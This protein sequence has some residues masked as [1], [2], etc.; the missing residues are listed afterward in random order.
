LIAINSKPYWLNHT[1]FAGEQLQFFD[2]LVMKS[3]CCEISMFRQ[4]DEN[5][6]GSLEL[7][8]FLI[9][10]VKAGVPVGNGCFTAQFHE[11]SWGFH[12]ETWVFIWI[13]M[14]L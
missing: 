14:D 4:F 9:L 12:Q 6:S 13:D 2:F 1:C 10:L 11:G 5:D 3:D 7:D 8:E